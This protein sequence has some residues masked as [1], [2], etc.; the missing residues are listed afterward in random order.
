MVFVFGYVTH[1][2]FY[3][4]HSARLAIMM[5]K[6]SHVI[7]LSSLIKSLEN[8]SY[9]RELVLEHLIRTERTATQISTFEMSF[10][11]DV[12]HFKTK[13]INTI[14]HTHPKFFKP[15]LEFD[16]WASAMKYLET[17]KKAALAFWRNS[18]ND[19]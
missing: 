18:R 7:Y 11:K 9:T 19:Q 17:N 2:T 6:M 5:I 3:F 8:L 12:E 4:L 1:K 13:S 16:D 14:I 15:I 10:N